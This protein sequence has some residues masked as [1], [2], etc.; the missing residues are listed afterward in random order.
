MFF[1]LLFF[2]GIISNNLN[3]YILSY[4]PSVFY[5]EVRATTNNT[6]INHT[7]D[8]KMSSMSTMLRCGSDVWPWL[9]FQCVFA[10]VFEIAP[11]IAEWGLER[12]CLSCPR[13]QKLN[14][15]FNSR[16]LD[17][18]QQIFPPTVSPP[19]TSH[20]IIPQLAG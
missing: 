9:D 12:V 19:T 6:G 11:R 10:S 18:P 16:L 3:S 13:T 15:V 8:T 7:W 2:L 4:F 20:R 1:P 5:S 14:I 17:F